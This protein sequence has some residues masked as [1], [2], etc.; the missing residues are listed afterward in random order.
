MNVIPSVLALALLAFGVCSHAAEDFVH[1]PTGVRLPAELL[2]FVRGD[3]IDHETNNPGH[4][5]SIPYRK[6]GEH[7]A[8]LIVFTSRLHPFPSSLDDPAIAEI[9]KFTVSVLLARAKTREP[10]SL[11]ANSRH[12][13]S[14]KWEAPGPEKTPVLVDMFIVYIG[15]RATND[16]V[17]MWLAG[18]H[19]WKLRVTKEGESGETSVAFVKAMVQLSV[20]EAARNRAPAQ[21]QAAL[22]VRARSGS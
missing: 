11:S 17:H 22:D 9:R 16:V 14:S 10:L 19:I 3:V 1:E 18:N 21:Q 8:T 4:G 20:A 7:S 13:S 6:P 5:V 15:G 2:G 12:T